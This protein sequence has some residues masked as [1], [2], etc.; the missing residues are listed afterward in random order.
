MNKKMDDT[1]NQ[2]I[3]HH[4]NGQKARHN[5]QMRFPQ[6]IKSFSDPCCV[7]NTPPSG[8]T[9]WWRSFLDQANVRFGSGADM[10]SARTNVRHAPEADMSRRRL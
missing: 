8:K 6:G 10:C 5:A 3:P 9:D 7:K 1:I 4:P 2:P